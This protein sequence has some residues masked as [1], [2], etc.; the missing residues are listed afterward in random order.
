M[1]EYLEFIKAKDEIESAIRSIVQ[2]YELNDVTVHNILSPI[3]TQYYQKAK[4][5]SNRSSTVETDSNGVMYHIDNG[6]MVSASYEGLSSS[7]NDLM[8]MAWRGEDIGFIGKKPE[9]C[10][11]DKESKE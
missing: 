11:D 10:N 3:V 8:R 7:K 9:H 6:P 4:E 1:T 5:P 2:K